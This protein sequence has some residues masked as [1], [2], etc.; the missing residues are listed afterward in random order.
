MPKSTK[1]QAAIPSEDFV[2]DL[3]PEVRE[4]QMINL[5]VRQ[6]EKQL[7]EGT[8]PA[9]VVTHYL[10]LA[11]AREKKE[12]EILDKQAELLTAKKEA[13]EMNKHIEEL[14][15]EAIS[16]MKIYRYDVEGTGDE[17]EEKLFRAG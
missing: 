7:R 1:K 10:K 2:P 15:A 11:T 3:N 4:A 8:A 16:A 5:A 13:I 14:Y 9:Q 12:L 6:A 17:D